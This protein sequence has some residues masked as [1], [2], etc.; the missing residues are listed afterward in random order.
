MIKKALAWLGLSLAVLFAVL[1]FNAFRAKRWPVT[2][3]A[4]AQ[5]P[6]PD[7]AI[8]HLV[9]AIRIQTVTFSDSTALDTV[10][11]KSFGN[12]LER[13]Y[14]LVHQ[15]TSRTT[16]RELSLVFEW[17]GTDSTMAPIVLMGHYDVVPV[18]AAVI[19]Q[20]L[21]PPF[22]GAVKDSCIWG[23]G[24][25][26]DKC[27][28][29]SILE[30]AESLL[31]E[32]FAPKRSIYF[33]FG[34]DEEISGQGA[35]AIAKYLGQK[36]V[37]AEMVLDEGGQL[38]TERIKE[39]KRPVAV[40]GVGEKG[41][42][43]FELSVRSEGG[44]SMMPAKETAIDI[45]AGALHKLR[46]RNPPAKLTPTMREFIERIG[47]SSESFSNRIAST[48]LWLFKGI[49]LS[50]LAAMPEGNAMIR[51]TIVPTI[52]KSG[53]KDNMIPATATAIVNARILPGETSASVEN[54]IRETIG[55]NRV[56]IKKTGKYDSEP[57]SMTPVTSSAFKR[58][59]SAL[60][61][62]IAGVLPVPYL[63]IGATDSRYY[64]SIA[65]GVVNFYPMTDAR[66]FH[67]VNERL[68]FK[69][70]QLGINFFKTIII[71]SNEQF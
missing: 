16:I 67:G 24:A 29:V 66:G 65:D 63:G 69:D 34:H 22:S 48:N 13:A 47:S 3:P 60:N 7:S 23:R 10:A 11:F 49:A 25:V 18:E 44:H 38:T 12:F 30:A 15:R 45:L 64:R 1:L 37:R 53:I 28:V 14:P 56:A 9:Q 61:K 5:A 55:D 26:D 21:V 54:Y 39:V 19:K 41:Y 17:K 58:V 27:G 71:E 35:K 68:T 52:I 62:N 50:R 31:R 42:A 57:S 20:W 36:N 32:G 2:I 51:T 33:C 59:E 40:I 4:H 6:I 46:R 8:Q 70:L 43:S